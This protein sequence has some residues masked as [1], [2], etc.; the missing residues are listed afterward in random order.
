MNYNEELEENF[1][2]EEMIQM[3]DD[4]IK[5]MHEYEKEREARKAE[6]EKKR[7]KEEKRRKVKKN[8][9]KRMAISAAL[10]SAITLSACIFIKNSYQQGR[11]ESCL[12]VEF[13]NEL[14][15]YNISIREDSQAGYV[16]TIDGKHVSYEEG[17]RMLSH[18]GD[19]C[20]L[21]DTEI[22]VAIKKMYTSY[23][24]ADV[25]GEEN[26]PSSEEQADVK[27]AVY[28]EQCAKEYRGNAK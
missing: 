1:T 13:S 16:F 18:I 14:S 19:K 8:N 21:S 7:K 15:Q 2:K 5:R 6:L 4:D 9:I 3:V 24:A 23:M 17:V 28:H 10:A 22:Y 26:V 27:K 12:A 11:G 20:G 25:V